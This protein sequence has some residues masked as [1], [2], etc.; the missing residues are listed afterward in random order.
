MKNLILIFIFSASSLFAFAHDTEGKDNQK[1]SQQGLQLLFDNVKNVSISGDRDAKLQDMLQDIADHYGSILGSAMSGS[2]DDE[3]V[4]LKNV[5]AKCTPVKRSTGY[6]GDCEIGLEYKNGDFL[7]I[8]YFVDLKNKQPYR[9][10]NNRV[11]IRR[12]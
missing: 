2:D 10:R 6:I 9:I 3:D 11:G 5:S 4:K 12:Y 7:E 1:F 8:S